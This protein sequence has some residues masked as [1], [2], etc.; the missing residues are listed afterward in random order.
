[1]SKFAALALKPSGRMLVVH[2]ATKEPLVDGEGRQAYIDL[3]S[4]DSDAARK[5]RHAL[6]NKRIEAKV[7]RVLTAEEAEREQLA[8]LAAM[9]TGWYLLDPEGQPLD[10][11]FTTADA[12]DLYREVPWLRDQVDIYLGDRANFWKASSES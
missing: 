3:H 4:A 7:S 6:T 12:A 1:M 11:P 2:P 5:W 10:V 9:T 8:F